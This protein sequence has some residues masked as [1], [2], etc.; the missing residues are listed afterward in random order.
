MILHTN[1]D[2]SFCRRRK[3]NRVKKLLTSACAAGLFGL[4]FPAQATPIGPDPVDIT[5]DIRV[6]AEKVGNM[7]RKLGPGLILV[8][9]TDPS[10]GTFPTI[11]AGSPVAIGDDLYFVDQVDGV[12]RL[13]DEGGLDTVFS[14]EDGDAPAGLDLENRQAVMNISEGRYADT[15]YIV[16]TANGPGS[17]QGLPS[18][19]PVYEM[20]DPVGEACCFG[21]GF[22]NNIYD[23][24]QSEL[25]PAIIAGV[26]PPFAT[27]GTESQILFEGDLVAGKLANLQPIAVFESQSGPHHHGGGMLTLPDGRVLYVTGDGIPFG[28][29][30]RESAQSLDSHLSKLLIVDPDDGSIS[31]VATGLRNVQHLEY[32]DA[33]GPV[34]PTIGFADVGGWTAEEINFVE[35]S[36]LLDPGKVENFGWGI[37]PDD[38]LAREGTFYVGPGQAFT[39]GTPPVQNVAPSPEMDFLQPHAQYERPANG[40]PN[41]GLASTGPVTSKK[42]LRK[43]TTLFSDL[44]SGILY[45]TT[46]DFDDIATTVYKL[47]VVGE[48]GMAYESL[49]KLAGLDRVD[50]RFFRFPDGTAGVLFEANGDF[51]RLTELKK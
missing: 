15:M 8:D 41:G 12:L 32:V 31:I 39:F 7:P 37:N 43:L 35:V 16:L 28:M 4:V 25:T 45:G 10:L 9:P 40:D 11:N 3:T 14:I 19:V 26:L 21:V 34:K 29:N 30:G 49:E 36:E 48:N 17:V 47:T 18:S 27:N 2:L 38:G 33:S 50:P 5:S 6:L 24:Q 44:D 22:L 51:Y 46:G 1:R 23:V 42:S 20:P 13:N